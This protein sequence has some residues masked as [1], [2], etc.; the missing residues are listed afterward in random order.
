MKFQA[1][2]SYL[3]NGRDITLP[4]WGG[5]W[6]WSN[7]HRTIFM[8]TRD[9]KIIDIRKSHDMAYTLSFIFRDDWELVPRK[10]QTSETVKEKASEVKYEGDSP[11]DVLITKDLIE[12]I[13]TDPVKVYGFFEKYR[14]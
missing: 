7:E 1:A 12:A 13:R 14:L 5:F 10:G 6:R 3:L 4:E 9:G 2:Y 11:F 8:Y